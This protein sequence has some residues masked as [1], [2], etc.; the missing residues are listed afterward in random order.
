MVATEVTV[1]TMV[2]T[3][4][5]ESAIA[6]MTDD[7]TMAVPSISVSEAM[8]IA[9]TEAVAQSI[10]VTVSWDSSYSNWGSSSDSNF[11]DWGNSN[12]SNFSWAVVCWKEKFRLHLYE[13]TR[14]LM[15]TYTSE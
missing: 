14:I 12:G 5:T 1:T 3:I 15:P 11:C 8:S 9:V 2:A 6:T 4:S 13:K 10:A 7:Y